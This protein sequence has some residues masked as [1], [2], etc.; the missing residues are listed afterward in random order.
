VLMN[1]VVIST[2]FKAL[3]EVFWTMF[4]CYQIDYVCN[5]DLVTGTIMEIYVKSVG[6]IVHADLIT[7]AMIFTQTKSLRGYI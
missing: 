2:N 7:V 1:L 5:R 6:N 3:K 4:L